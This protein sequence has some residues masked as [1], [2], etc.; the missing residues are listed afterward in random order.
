MAEGGEE[1]GLPERDGPSTRAQGA[2]GG[3]AN[4][5]ASR[6]AS[7][8]GQGLQVVGDK[9]GGHSFHLSPAPQP[10]PRQ[11]CRE[12]ALLPAKEELRQR[13]W[14]GTWWGLQRGWDFPSAP[15]AKTPCS[16]FRGYAE[17]KDLAGL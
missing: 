9:A 12:Q 6:V 14:K 4:R 13:E 17:L 15:V 16:Q 1:R 10:C 3:L 8:A 5:R 2:W 11:E 7:T